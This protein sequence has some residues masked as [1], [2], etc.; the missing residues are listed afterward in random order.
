MTMKNQLRILLLEDSS[1]DAELILR[2]LRKNLSP[3]EYRLASTSDKFKEQLEEFR[4]ELILCDNSVPSFSAREALQY[5]REIR[6]ALPFILI[7]GTVSEDFAVEIIK[8]GADDYILKDRMARLPSA[9][10][11]TMT[12]RETEAAR[13]A[14]ELEKILERDRLALILNTL[15]ANVALLDQTGIIIEVNDSWKEFGRHGSFVGKHA[16]VGLNYLTVSAAAQGDDFEDGQKVSRG[17][18]DLLNDSITEFTHEYLCHSPQGKAWYRMI[19]TRL[20][21]SRH[22]GAVVMHIDITELRMLE[23]ERLQTTIHEERRIAQAILNAQEQERNAIGIE[24]HDNVNQILVGTNLFLSLAKSHP[25]TSGELI[26]N[27][28]GNIRLAIQENRKIA[29]ELVGPDLAADSLLN[30]IKILVLSMLSTAGMNVD[31]RTQ[32]FDETFLNADLRFNIYRIIQE[33]CTNIVKYSRARN[34]TVSLSTILSVFE[35]S[36]SDDGV[37]Q[38]EASVNQGIGLKNIHDRVSIF[39]GKVLVRTSKGNGFSLV[40]NIPYLPVQVS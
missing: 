30:Q 9:I 34:V 25:E 16:S 6:P 37:G 13:I 22:S 29:H 28:M 11:A 18:R 8:L 23:L 19:A 36:I 33:Q 38:K 21:H 39:D 31:L 7:T 40:I 2:L 35:L 15:P 24:L 1:T 14:A 3:F 26:G 17:L 27:A 12:K 4:P 10:I 32:S 5:V 20:K